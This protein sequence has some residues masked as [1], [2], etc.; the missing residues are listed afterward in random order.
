LHALIGALWQMMV[1]STFT[2]SISL[3]TFV[4]H[5]LKEVPLRIPSLRKAAPGMA[6][7][8]PACLSCER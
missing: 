5:A 8:T 3:R 7:T 2:A 4:S 6:A 1:D